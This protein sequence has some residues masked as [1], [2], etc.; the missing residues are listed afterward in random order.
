MNVIILT[1]DPDHPVVHA[2]RSWQAD[3]V[4]RGHTVQICFD[5]RD[6]VAADI[7][8]LV[9]CAQIIS[10]ADRHPYRAVLVLHASDLP[11]G[12]GWSPH[13]W[14]IVGGSN[15]ITVCLLEAREPVD[16]GPVWLRTAIKLDG[17]ELLPEINARLFAAEL[18]LMTEAVERFHELIPVSQ[19]G[20]PGPYMQRRTPEHSRLDPARTI[21]DQFDL[22]RVVDNDRYPAF[23]EHRGHRY[24]LRITKH[25]N[26]QT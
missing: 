1:S 9:S 19:H 26:A 20:D 17:H 23:F 15:R 7:L 25:D 2:L 13:I 22:L 24:V 14:S 5:K 3:M 8:F 6:L 21:A 16:S 11:E 4:R 12:R 10:E 18:G